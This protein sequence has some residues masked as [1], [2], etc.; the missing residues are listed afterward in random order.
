LASVADGRRPMGMN[1]DEEIVYDLTAEIL[2]NKRISDATFQ[3]AEQRFGKKG[4]VDMVGIAG[5]YTFLAMQLNMAR[6][7]FS[8]EGARLSRFPN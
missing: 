8:G 7:Q 5:Y 2:K 4:V 3:R 6:Y 1:A